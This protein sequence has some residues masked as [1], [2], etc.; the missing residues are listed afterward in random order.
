MALSDPLITIY[1]N[2]DV[3]KT[4]NVEPKGFPATY[5]YDEMQAKALEN[6]CP[7]LVKGGVNGKWYLKGQGKSM[8]VI[9]QEIRHKHGKARKGV[10]L[11]LI[12][13]T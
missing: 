1:P 10:T 12:E 3:W 4:N 7:I 11:Y 5:T 8:D 6:N 9:R 13:N 2:T